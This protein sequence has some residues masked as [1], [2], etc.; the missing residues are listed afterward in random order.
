[1]KPPGIAVWLERHGLTEL[2]PVFERHH[3]D[4][5]VLT[6]LTDE[7]LKEMGVAVGLR[8]KLLA[9]LQR[10]RSEGPGTEAVERRHLTVLFVDLVGS[11]PL[12]VEL[13][14]EELREL[15]HSFHGTVNTQVAALD[16]YVAQ[17]KGDGALVYFGYPRAHEDDPQRAISAAL[18]IVRE[19]AAIRERSSQPIAAHLGIATGLAVVGDT[20][21]QLA[22]RERSAIGET[23]NL[24]ARLSDLA[25]SGEVVVS[26]QTARLCGHQFEFEPLAP[27][28]LKGIEDPV[29]A[30]RVVR[31]RESD[32]LFD[33]RRGPIRGVMV[34][35]DAELARLLQRWSAAEHGQGQLVVIS[36]EAGIG[37]SRLVKALCEALQDRSHVQVLNQCS[38]HHARTAF[39]PLRR[40]L[41]QAAGLRPGEASAESLDRLGVLLRGAD[42]EDVALTAALLDID[43]PEP[44]VQ[45]RMT[46]GELRQRTF[47]ALL[48][49]L[50]REAA[51]TP[52]LW[53][54]E[55]AHWID[56]TTL[57]LMLQ[58]IPRIAKARV[59]AVVTCRPEFELPLPDAEHVH[60]IHL[61]RLGVAAIRSM[62]QALSRA[63]AVSDEVVDRIAARTDGVPLYIEELY[64]SL[65][66]GGVLAERQGVVVARS[67][68]DD[69]SIP[70]SLHDSL[71]ARLDHHRAY[72]ELAQTAA[73]IGRE[74]DVDLL[75]L[76]AALPVLQIEPALRGLEDAEIV[77]PVSSGPPRTY[78]F[79]HALVRDAAYESLLIRRREELHGSIFDVLQALPTTPPELLARHAA[80]A[81]RPTQAIECWTRAAR[82]A[83][84]R[85]AFAEAV[86]HLGQALELNLRLGQAPEHRQQRLDLL[87]ALGQASIPWR[88]YSH[89]ETVQAFEQASHLA[90]EVNDDQRSFWASYARWVVYYVRGEHVVAHRIACEMLANAEAAGS[91]GRTLAAMRSRGISEMI[92]GQPSSAK[93]LFDEADVRALELRSRP[94]EQRMAMA[95]RFAAD[96]EIATQ[97]HVALT[98]WSLGYPEEALAI[99]ALAVQ[100][101]RAL[102]HVHTLGHALVH[103]AIVAI[104]DLNPELALPLCI[105]AGEFATRHG[106]SLWF[107]Y[108]LI[109][110]GHAQLLSGKT[111]AGID[112]LVNGLARMRLMETGTMVPLH[113]AVCAWALAASGQRE[114]ARIYAERVSFELRRGCERFFWPDML[115]LQARYLALTPG[116]ADAQ[117]EASLRQALDAA[118]AQGAP[119]MGLK[120]ATALGHHLL[121]RGRIAEADNKLARAMAQMPTRGHGPVWVQALALQQSIQARRAH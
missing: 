40:H 95:Q 87:L 106:M 3:V 58:S 96:P 69:R 89:T 112:A 114:Q 86:S 85:A 56:P 100:E 119:S 74:F 93:M 104:V 61:A 57:E 17:Y 31:E 82:K 15:L 67:N 83:L 18:A 46:P 64:R 88:G 50:A 20:F 43:S 111:D 52:I 73:V 113:D 98:R 55:D 39:Y 32:S 108:A 80:A 65:V 62:V 76:V 79:K 101:A 51:N 19:L 81:G 84:S 10:L 60:V 22:A 118:D 121:A 72:R 59:L 33:A 77:H 7:H 71:M 1:M 105:E 68:I 13:D 38:P 2:Q 8:L 6:M 75:A 29:Q 66:E 9:T 30:F 110:R 102:G 109:L 54:V 94:N 25:A 34:G 44:A 14:P 70:S 48:A 103:G 12:S 21:G 99:S 37:K 47:E 116:G 24:A 117:V 45:T 5:D 26:A 49:Q 78:A 36:G 23:P 63:E 16:G 91:S 4:V 35:R 11:T 120:A 92:L 97:F 41:A 42:R 115:I 90:K 27:R 107:G 28:Q 53:L